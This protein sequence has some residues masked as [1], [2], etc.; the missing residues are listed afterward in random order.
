[1]IGE[2]LIDIARAPSGIVRT[3]PGGAAANVAL[4]LARLGRPVDL[5]THVGR[6]ADGVAVVPPLEAAG[7][8][9]VPVHRR[10][11]GQTF[12]AEAL[13]DAHGNATYTFDIDWDVD[14]GHVPRA[15]LVVHT[16]CLGAALLPGAD[17]VL[18]YLAGVRDTS[19]ISYDVNIRPAAVDGIIDA[20]ER[21]EAFVR[22]SDVVKASDDDLAWFAGSGAVDATAAEWACSGAAVVVTRGAGGATLFRGAE[23]VH[24]PAMPVAVA[25]TIGAGDAFCAG[26]VDALWNEGA[27]G[28]GARGDLEALPTAQWRAV[29]KRAGRIAGL[30][31]GRP[32][33]DPP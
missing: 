31:V 4:G 9:V 23:R 25:D 1:M 15:P 20:R 3:H 21:V 13:L 16:G 11:D 30:T 33:A 27:L 6:D 28:A 5:A 8:D 22:I 10:P 24:V 12:T 7:V 32:G 17:A 18:H 26:L 19:T 14:L 2:T 29:L